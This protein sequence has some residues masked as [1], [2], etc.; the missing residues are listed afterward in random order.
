M[1]QLN[2]DLLSKDLT[3]AMS[4]AAIVV[5]NRRAT[6]LTPAFV[7]LALVRQTNIAAA[8]MLDALSVSRGF[9]KRQIERQV[10]MS[11]VRV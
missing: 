8:R 1:G 9:Q 7:L 6:Y 3:E 2:P 4:A 11:A 10:A 5:T